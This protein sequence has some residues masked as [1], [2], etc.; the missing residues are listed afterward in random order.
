MESPEGRLQFLQNGPSSAC[1][2]LSRFRR[3]ASVCYLPPFLKM[4][5]CVLRS[6]GLSLLHIHRLTQTLVL[7]LDWWM[8]WEGHSNHIGTWWLSNCL[9]YG[10]WTRLEHM[11][12]AICKDANSLLGILWA[13]LFILFCQLKWMGSK[14]HP[15]FSTTYPLVPRE[16]A[17]PPS[18]CLP[19]AVGVSVRERAWPLSSW[20]QILDGAADAVALDDDLWV[21]RVQEHSVPDR[22]GCFTGK[23][24]Q[25]WVSQQ[26]HCD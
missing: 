22:G 15:F 14:V 23:G 9:V 6:Y 24:P 18:G 7:Y 10:T 19:P 12:V 20:A 4:V 25:G 3:S 8:R 16:E 11:L 5:S 26:K 21:G 1:P 2:E 17:A 13:E